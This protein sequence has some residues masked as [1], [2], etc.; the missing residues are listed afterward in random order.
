[1]EKNKDRLRPSFEFIQ[2]V[3]ET[4]PADIRK[5]VIRLTLAQSVIGLLDLLAVAIIGLL[6]AFTVQNFSTVEKENDF[7]SFLSREPFSKLSLQQQFLIFASLS[8]FLLIVKTT[9]SAILA[10]K[11][12]DTLA[13]TS[14]QTTARLA[15][16]IL[17]GGLGIIYSQSNQSVAFALTRGVEVLILQIIAPLTW[18]MSD[19]LLLALLFGSL[20]FFDLTTGITSLLFFGLVGILLNQVTNKKSKKLGRI[21]SSKNIESIQLINSSLLLYRVVRIRGTLDRVTK[22]IGDSR[23]GVSTSL[24]QL[25]FLQ[26]VGKYIIEVALV[27]GAV[28]IGVTQ[29][30]LHDSVTAT[31][32][33]VLFLAAGI[34][35]APSI[36]RIQQC[37]LLIRSGI[38]LSEV[39]LNLILGSKTPK[40][41]SSRTSRVSSVKFIPTVKLDNVSLSL[42]KENE[43]TILSNVS[44]DIHPGEIVALSGVS[45]CG[46]SSL[47]DVILGFR[48]PSRGSALVSGVSAFD[49]ADFWPQRTGLVPQELSLIDGTIKENIL[50]GLREDEYDEVSLMK[51][52]KFADLSDFVESL[53]NGLNHTITDNGREL[54]GGQKQRIAIARAIIT[55]PQLLVLDEATAGLDTKSE[56]NVMSNLRGYVKGVESRAVIFATHKKLVLQGADKVVF[57]E[58]G[59]VTDLGDFVSLTERNSNFK[60]MISIYEE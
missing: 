44:L 40:I 29:L 52:I 55:Q 21:V 37:F 49:I 33:F 45:G 30:M 16:S 59:E 17:E 24:A 25:A 51:A 36:L 4:L 7:L 35:I 18:L 42:S 23:Q 3:L 34:R 32:N 8:A 27:I 39:T 50:L 13:S 31:M 20:I 47:I 46:K 14:S 38:G 57:I 54:S 9:Y 43:K 15:R 53:Q 2:S 6:S 22:L 5:R 28:L 12:T 56:S 10:R 41:E 60:K 48:N 1:M 11:L 58:N 26:F 19:L